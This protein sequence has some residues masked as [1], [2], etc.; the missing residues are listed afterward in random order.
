MNIY[1][2]VAILYLLLISTFENAYLFSLIFLIVMM[3]SVCIIGLFK[4]IISPKIFLTFSILVTALIT[5]IVEY[6][7]YKYIPGFYREVGI[8]LPIMMLIL[9]DTKEEDLSL[10]IKKTFKRCM[11][12]ILLLLVTGLIKE[13]LFTN[14]ITLMNNI[15]SIT[16]Y[17][18]IIHLT[19]NN[20]IP[21]SSSFNLLIVGLI[22]GVATK[23]RG[24]INA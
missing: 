13:I 23:I 17:R 7:V 16:G 1:I 2:S 11:H 18:S 5:T 14:Q 6:L 9:Y 4:K 3:S 8:Y 21:I 12:Y 19:E 24:D 10:N 15:S 22:L 20:I